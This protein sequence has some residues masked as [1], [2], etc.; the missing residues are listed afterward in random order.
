[1]ANT[2]TS[3]YFDGS[4]DVLFFSGTPGR[5]VN[6]NTGEFVAG[7]DDRFDFGSGDFTIEFWINSISLVYHKN[8]VIFLPYVVT[9]S[10][11][12]LE[13]LTFKFL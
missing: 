8:L 7:G 9:C 1:M 5:D 13:T 12:P 10:L 3:M 2:A 6:Y 11:K 4:D